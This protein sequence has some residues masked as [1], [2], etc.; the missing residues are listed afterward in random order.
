[1]AFPSAALASQEFAVFEVLV[2]VLF[3]SDSARLTRALVLDGELA[4][5]ASAWLGGFR[6]PGLLQIDCTAVPEVSAEK[7]LEVVLSEFASVAAQGI[8][9]GELERAQAKLEADA[10]R[11]LLSASSIAHGLGMHEVTTGRFETLFEG[12]AHIQAVTAESVQKLAG[13]LLEG[14]RFVVL[15]RPSGELPADDGDDGGDWEE[16]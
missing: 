4:S 11:E 10:V 7:M 5:G 2:E 9:A 16:D 13:K 6:Y 8:S 12:S 1:M 3:N 15:G 14:P